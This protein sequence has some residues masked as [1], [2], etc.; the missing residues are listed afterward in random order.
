VSL[1]EKLNHLIEDL[2]QSK[3]EELSSF[4]QA[5][6]KDIEAK[7]FQI[8]R[9]EIDSNL[10]NNILTNTIEELESKKVMLEKQ[11]QLIEEQ[12]RFKEILF[13]NVSHELRTPLHGI[14][15]MSRLLFNSPLN[16]E[17]HEFVDIIKNSADNLLVIINDILNLSKINS[18]N[19]TLS[20]NVFETATLFKDLKGIFQEKARRKDLELGLLI[21]PSIPEF[22][23][24]DYTRLSQI[25]LNLLNNAIKFTHKGY[26]SLSVKSTPVI[27]QITE[28]KFEIKDTGI[29]IK[30]E[31][32]DQ[33]FDSFIQVHEDKG[34]V[35]EGAGLGLN[36]ARNLLNLMSG[37]ISVDSELDVGTTFIVTIPFIVP[38]EEA[39]TKFKEKNTSIQLKECWHLQKILIVED[40]MANLLY[41]RMLLKENGIIPDEAET[42]GRALELIKEK[43]YDFL[44]IDVKLPDGNG[45]DLVE[46]IRADE[47]GLNHQANVLVL[48]A[49]ANEIEKNSLAHLNITAYLPKPFPPEVLLNELRKSRSTKNNDNHAKS[50]SAPMNIPEFILETAEN[51]SKIIN[52]LLTIYLEELPKVLKELDDAIN[53][54]DYNK[55]CYFSH[56]F[57]S[58]NVFLGLEEAATILNQIE[59]YANSKK[60][61]SDIQKLI[62]KFQT[63]TNIDKLLVEK[64]LVLLTEKENLD[65]LNKTVS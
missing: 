18:G 63:Q 3:K 20:S 15:G 64:Q 11:N 60:D 61:I 47:N 2:N 39:I 30:Q 7:T 22:L 14:I 13:T 59:F 65:A 32:L 62:S 36:I 57:K 38:K 50:I 45:I 41:A 29:G 26:V 24:G 8:K 58:N 54:R 27:N 34:I 51:N 52:E 43:T 33:I 1:Q 42:M 9:H 5:L 46:K 44:L 35:Y 31:E 10:I 40:N 4:F 55:I 56:K 16:S 12:A 25:L 19:I 37:T 53:Q 23:I 17:Q 21:S 49:S 28:I 48:T 6:N